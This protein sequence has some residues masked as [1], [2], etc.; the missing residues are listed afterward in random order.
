MRAIHY[1]TKDTPRN[2]LVVYAAIKIV[3]LLGTILV[4]LRYQPSASSK[5]PMFLA[6]YDGVW[7]RGIAYKD[8]PI[9]LRIQQ[10]QRAFRIQQRSCPCTRF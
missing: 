5:N 6:N 3:V 9:T 8:T 4:S 7:Y 1:Y 10:R 2:T